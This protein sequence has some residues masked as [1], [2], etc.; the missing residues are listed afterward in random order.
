MMDIDIIEIC[1]RIIKPKFRRPGKLELQ[2]KSPCA[3]S[4]DGKLSDK[5]DC[6]DTSSNLGSLSVSFL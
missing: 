5:F 3:D 4:S 6:F 1:D 2:S